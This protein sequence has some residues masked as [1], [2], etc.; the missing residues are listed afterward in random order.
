MTNVL[1]KARAELKEIIIEELSKLN[2]PELPINSDPIEGDLSIICFPA[3]K[4]M[5]KAPEEVANELA[6]HLLKTTSI[7][8]IEIVNGYCNITIDWINLMPKIIDEL[9]TDDFG[10]GN[11]KNKKILIEHTSANATGPL[12]IGRARNPII[13]D[14]MARLLDFSGYQVETE[15]YVNDMGR[16]ACTLAYGIEKHPNKG[17]GKIDYQLVECYKKGTV[18]LEE[19][20]EAKKDI[21]DLMEECESGDVESLTKVNG[22]SKKVLEGMKISLDRL[23]VTPRIFTYESEL[24]TSGAVQKVISLLQNSPLCNE[25]GGALYLDLEEKGIAGRNQKFFFT[26]KNGLSLYTTRDVAYHMNKF[27]RC[28]EALNILGEDHKLQGKLLTIALQEISQPVP[29]SMFYSFV[30]LPGGKMSTRAGRVVYLDE[31]MDEAVL[32]AKREIEKRRKD[33]VGKSLEELSEKIG[34]GAI[35]YNIIRIQSDKGFKFKWEEALN[36]EGDSAPFVMYSH[37]R[38]SSI[39]KKI[40]RENNEGVIPKELHLSELKLIRTLMKFPS[41]VAEATER[42]KPHK[43]PYYLQTLSS[44]FNKFYRDCPVVDAEYEWFRKE[45]VIS[46]KKVLFEGLGILGIDAPEIM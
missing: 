34:I 37:A 15:Y 19:S 21:Y 41:I 1:E 33:I 46:T 17:E 31:M 29:K 38:A 42:M 24:I 43:M 27:E 25:E 20:K 4:K 13:G 39:L 9:N 8:K 28:D 2:W 6:E 35:R 22:A 7:K 40:K 36:F 26:R 5:N 12:H 11:K 23:G 10:K 44:N 3:A 32:L 45:L 14:T 18:D 16:Q 30:S